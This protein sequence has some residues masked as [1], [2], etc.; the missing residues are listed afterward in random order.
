MPKP[1]TPRLVGGLGNQLFG[2]YAGAALAAHHGVELRLDTS[3]TRHG[4]TDHGIEILPLDLPGTWLRNDSL[5]AKLSAPGTIPG[6]AVAKAF[7][8]IPQLGKRLRLRQTPE[9]GRRPQNNGRPN[10]RKST[11]AA[12]FP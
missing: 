6:R 9:S 10:L 8:D 12:R 11:P 7:R 3:W 1:I 2:Y 4:I 5:G